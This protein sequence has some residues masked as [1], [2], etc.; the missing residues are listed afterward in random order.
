[1]KHKKRSRSQGKPHATLLRGFGGCSFWGEQC[2]R[3]KP[4]KA[5]CFRE[6]A[7]FGVEERRKGR[8]GKAEGLYPRSKAQAW[9]MPRLLLSMPEVPLWMKAVLEAP[10]RHLSGGFRTVGFFLAPRPATKMAHQ[11]P[12]SSALCDPMA[13]FGERRS[14]SRPTWGFALAASAMRSRTET[15][16]PPAGWR[17]WVDAG[18]K[19]H[20][21]HGSGGQLFLRRVKRKPRDQETT[22]PYFDT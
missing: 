13:T 22:K 20:G 10:K 12:P 2:K 8:Q 15:R 7:S 3:R 19:A 5:M 16:P 14:T 17:G 18:P 9:N 6:N 21:T 4:R 11:N 1:M